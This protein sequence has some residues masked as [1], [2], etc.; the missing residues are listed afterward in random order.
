M[1][2]FSSGFVVWNLEKRWNLPSF[3][4]K[5]IFV[6]SL[7]FQWSNFVLC[8]RAYREVDWFFFQ[9]KNSRTNQISVL[10]VKSTNVYSLPWQ[11]RF[12]EFVWKTSF[13]IIVKL[14]NLFDM[15]KVVEFLRKPR[16]FS[17][18]KYKCNQIRFQNQA[19][20]LRASC[21]RFL[22]TGVFIWHFVYA[23]ELL[24]LVSQVRTNRCC[25]TL[26]LRKQHQ[27]YRQIFDGAR[28]TKIE[29]K[30]EIFQKINKT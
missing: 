1:S 14:L 9:F 29:K 25:P 23:C 16:F 12:E 3:V 24:V 7:K 15:I 10:V 4:K 13:E 22:P 11:A 17:I 20:P 5:N 21:A 6:N 8:P 27:N 18:D 19:L 2:F 26:W 30:Y 28:C